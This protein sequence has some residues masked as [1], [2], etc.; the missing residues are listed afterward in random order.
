V[1]T[2]D[3]TTSYDQYFVDLTGVPA[4]ASRVVFMIVPEQADTAYTYSYTY[5]YVDDIQIRPIPTC[6]EPLSVTVDS[7]DTYEIDLSWI[8]SVG[9]GEHVVIEYGTTGFTLGTGDTSMV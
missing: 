5:A 2:V 9:V 1:D 6:T 3:I 4:N 7:V 8:G